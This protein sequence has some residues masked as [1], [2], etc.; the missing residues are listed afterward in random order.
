[1]RKVHAV[2][3]K[4]CCAINCPGSMGGK[5][6]ETYSSMRHREIWVLED[7]KG[8]QSPCRQMCYTEVC[9]D[10]KLLGLWRPFWQHKISDESASLHTNEHSV[11]R[12]FAR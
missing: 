5:L 3:A 1:M 6:Q 4:S 12:H 2:P 9:F 10:R 8:V 11:C 7:L